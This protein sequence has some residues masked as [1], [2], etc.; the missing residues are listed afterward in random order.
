[1]SHAESDRVV[2]I[3]R[4]IPGVQRVTKVFEYTD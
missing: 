3:A 2:E 4:G 1:V